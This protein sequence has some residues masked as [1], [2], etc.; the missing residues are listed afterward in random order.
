MTVMILEN[1]PEKLRG[2]LTRWMLETKPGIFVGSV[3]ALVR[4]KLW[5]KVTDAVPVIPALLIYSA[6]CEQ[7]FRIDMN[8]DPHRRVIEM[9]GVQFIKVMD[10]DKSDN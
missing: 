9:E 2:E 1:A 3:S 5:K 4:E 7:G 6:S 8:G 10:I